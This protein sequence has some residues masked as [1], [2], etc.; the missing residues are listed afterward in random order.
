MR[1]G[2]ATMIFFAFFKAEGLKQK[3]F[4]DLP[5]LVRFN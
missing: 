4:S 2:I 1:I 5:Q 3:Q